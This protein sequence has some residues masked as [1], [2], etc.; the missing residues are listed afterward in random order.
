MGIVLAGSTTERLE[1]LF[2]DVGVAFDAVGVA[3][4][5]VATAIAGG[6]FAVRYRRGPRD[7]TVYRKLKVELGQ[8]LLLGLEI[9]VAAD[10]IKTVAVQPSF[11]SLGVLAVLIAI[12][13]ALSWSLMLEIDGRW[14]WSRP[15]LENGPTPAT[16]RRAPG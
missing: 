5:V 7:G 8:G 12:R 2:G 9:L 15:P 16:S 3:V 11:N 14:P 1:E 4:I 10:I 13:T 6:R